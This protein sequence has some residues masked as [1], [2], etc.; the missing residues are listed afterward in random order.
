[1]LDG[2]YQVIEPIAEGAMGIVYRGE[3]VGLGRAV[4]IKVMHESLPGELS[5]RQRFE[6]E[7]KL[8]ALL[9]HPN[10][11]SVIDFGLHEDKP[12]VIMELVRGTSLHEMIV[13]TG[14]FDVVH[15]A[16][17]LR[18]VLSGLG[19]AHEHGIVHRDIKPANIMVSSRVGL[20]EQV[21]ILD[22]GLARLRESSTHLTTGIVVGTPSYMAPEQCRG[23]EVD[24][25]VDLYAS[26]VMLFE[27]L[28]GRKPFVG[29]DPIMIVRKHLQEAPPRLSDVIS[30]DF[31]ALEDVIARALQKD[32][33]DRYPSAI[34]MSE[35]VEA[36]VGHR[37]PETN[38]GRAISHPAP[39]G[40]ASS[41]AT[42]S[43]WNVPEEIG[44][45][46]IL[47]ASVSPSIADAPLVSASMLTEEKS[48]GISDQLDSLRIL[49]E[50][51]TSEATPPR[52]AP[53]R[54]TEPPVR[55]PE[56]PRY[57]TGAG[58][59]RASTAPPEAKDP[60]DDSL[61]KTMRKQKVPAALRARREQPNDQ[62]RPKPSEASIPPTRRS[63]PNDRSI[64]KL[65]PRSRMRWAVLAG[66]I[67]VGLAIWG[68][69]AGKKKLEE[70]A[71]LRDGGISE[72]NP[73]E[74]DMSDPAASEVTRIND[75]FASGEKRAALDAAIKARAQY[76]QSAGL[77]YVAGRI[78]FSKFYWTDGIKNFRDAIRLDASYKTDAELIK[79]VLKG[80]ITTPD[81]DERIAGFLQELGPAAVPALEETARDHP[82]PAL[83][84]RAAAM[85]RRIHQ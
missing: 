34:E 60:N 56:Q 12:F 55:A 69:L 47:D 18:Q 50:Q 31:G 8:M 10:C 54:G 36:A 39:V 49:R 25:R 79:T 16:D 6:R 70:N 57:P 17:V 22:F 48:V 32:P 27:M 38:S 76:P 43:G 24:A 29:D 46:A 85:L 15:A 35:E 4:A 78:Y 20:G 41:D 83:R 30:E 73:H 11:V 63:D 58:V 3:R 13:K 65:L 64:L 66:A 21:R 2:R 23:G 75:L 62:S 51:A 67:L 81:T 84:S 33:N 59:S 1:M 19:H 77:A 71:A 72:I 80:F 45:S 68:I 82:N 14:R 7:A 53:R 9:E 40:R 74:I 37:R 26:G 61:L 28:T 5:S 42:P 44:S 52:A